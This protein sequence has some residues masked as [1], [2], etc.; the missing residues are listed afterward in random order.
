MKAICR[1]ILTGI[2][3]WKIEGEFPDI[4]KSVI[5]FAPHTSYWDGLYGKL[6]LMQLDIKYKFLSKK[7]FFKFP[8]KYFFRI[9]GSI[10]VYKNKTYIDY[11][12]GLYNNNK[13]LHIV[14]SP[15]G[16]L[17]R[18]TRWKKGYYYMAVKADVPIVVGYLDYKKKEIGIKK[19][20]YNPTN[21][22]IV[23]NEIAE[24]YS[25]VTAK[26]PE[27]FSLEIKI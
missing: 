1:Y 25:D 19:V 20:I 4:K 12:A 17:A 2:L 23:R 10:P 15:E 3:G 21:L 27:N 5:I 24:L 14:L 6:Y 16:Q 22:G 18:I 7:E 9:F 26:Y 11:I 13:E 8:M